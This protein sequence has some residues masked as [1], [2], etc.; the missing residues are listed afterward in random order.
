M[1]LSET[2]LL[3]IYRVIEKYIYKFWKRISYKNTHTDCIVLYC[4]VLIG[5]SLLSNAL[6]PF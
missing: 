4:F 2:M 3:K 5:L 6:R 1:T